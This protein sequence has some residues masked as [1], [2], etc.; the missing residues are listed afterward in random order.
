MSVI[1]YP[2]LTLNELSGRFFGLFSLSWAR[3]LSEVP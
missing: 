1:I 3:V 2:V